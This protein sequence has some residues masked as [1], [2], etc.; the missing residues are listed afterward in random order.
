MRQLLHALLRS[1]PT[2]CRYLFLAVDQP[3]T[4]TL[5]A[6]VAERRRSRAQRQQ[7][8]DAG[9][10]DIAPPQLAPFLFRDHAGGA[11]IHVV[12]PATISGPAPAAA[13]VDPRVKAA[14]DVDRRKAALEAALAELRRLNEAAAVAAGSDDPPPYVALAH[15][16]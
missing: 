11:G 3:I 8:N 15:T 2:S 5:D 1:D 10:K 7:E 4:S 12:A 16:R 14:A 13:V 6:L 9:L